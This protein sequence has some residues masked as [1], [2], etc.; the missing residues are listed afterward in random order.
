[1]GDDTVRAE[2]YRPTIRMLDGLIDI[3]QR[4]GFPIGHLDRDRIIEAARKSTGLDDFGDP[5]FLAPMER[6][7]ANAR[8][9]PFTS[10]GKAFTQMS[11]QRAIG[12]RLH[13]E[14]HLKEHPEIL[15]QQIRRPVFILGFPRTGTTLLQNLIAQAPNR[16]AL[17]FWEL[18]MPVPV[19]VSYT[20]LTLPTICSV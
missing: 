11:C 2:V 4:L 9:A 1:M 17:E 13:I 16:R 7:L 8:Q 15:N 19:P 10:L 18:T 5:S 20:H 3:S 12:N 6:L 14:A